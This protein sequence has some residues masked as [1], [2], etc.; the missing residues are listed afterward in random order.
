MK[1][2]FKFAHC[3]VSHPFEDKIKE[4]FKKLDRHFHHIVSIRLTMD[5]ENGHA[6]M[7]AVVHLPKKIMIVVE[8]ESD[9]M[10]KTAHQIVDII[11]R[12]VCQRKSRMQEH[13]EAS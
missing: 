12:K 3:P 8:S 13:R 2:I 6:K 5:V 9:D 11:D 4:L 1:L 10:Y 7:K